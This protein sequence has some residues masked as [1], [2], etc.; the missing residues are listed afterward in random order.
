ML[1]ATVVTTRYLYDVTPMYEATASLQIRD[2]V[3]SGGEKNAKTSANDLR[4][5]VE[6]IKSRLLFEKALNTLDFNVAYFHPG[7]SKTE[8]VYHAAPFNVSYQI[9]ENSF[10]KQAYDF[11]FLGG[12]RFKLVYTGTAYNNEKEGTFGAPICD[13]GLCI[14]ITK[15]EKVVKQHPA[16]YLSEPWQFTVNST[17]A[18]SN[19]LMNDQL[20]VK[21]VD[22]TTNIVKVTYRHPMPEK[23]AKLVNAIAGV[24]IEQG[25][26]ERQSIANNTVDFL[27]KQLVFTGNDLAN[28]RDAIK[29]Y[30]EKNEI[31]NIPLQT[32]T[33]YKTLGDL[34]SQKAET[35]IQLATL[36]QMSDY[37]RKNRKIT[38]TAPEL[39]S[40]TDPLF[41]DAVAKLNSKSLER[42]ELS[43]NSASADGTIKADAEIEQ[44]KT[45]LIESINNTRRKLLVKQDEL[46][47]AIGSEKATFKN[48][49]E[50]EGVMQELSQNYLLNDKTYDYLIQK[51]TE[52]IISQQVAVPVNRI[53]DA[54]VIPL[55]P[56]SPRSDLIWTLGLLL[57]LVIGV[58]LAYIVHFVKAEVDVPEDLTS[59]SSIPLMGQVEMLSK[60]NPA[61]QTFTALSTR[62]MMNRDIKKQMVITVTSTRKGEGKSYIA[63]H[64]A[65]TFAAMD[66][67]VLLIDAN[68]YQ[69]QQSTWFDV[70][71]LAG[72]RDFYTENISVQDIIQI[73]SIPSLDIIGAGNETHPIGHL[74]STAKT[75]EML[76]ELRTQY[77]TIII[78]TPD[79]G[80]YTDAIPF[81]KWSDLNLYVVKAES[82]KNELIAN[83]ELIKEEYRLE[84]VY[85]VINAMKEKRNHTGYV[86][87]YT[88]SL[89]AVKRSIP[90]LTNLFAW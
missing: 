50:K 9:K 29:E 16:E 62:I 24:Y 39:G 19:E 65:R 75:K 18:L 6:V 5:E 7:E 20:V 8:E 34:E 80:Q 44:L 83:A 49:P 79:A 51:R 38:L 43:K 84:E 23:A 45:F 69:P 54:G 55:Q 30:R 35:A 31:V 12:N 63:A 46:V 33:T 11:H 81:M 82:G 59:A 76:D 2:G 40:F 37:L 41:S 1:V 21:A 87:P 25:K 64:L 3:S 66:K 48:L 57:G 36:E 72:L 89:Q 22:N 27:N 78:D 77:D 10:Y 56:A 26:Q 15:N 13:R 60:L 32:A 68:T 14:T 74:I 90:Q 53:I 28:S 85:Y 61:Y 42:E 71:G 52:A 67:K 47:A 4:A 88:I 86:K 73:T 58:V 17:A 70:R